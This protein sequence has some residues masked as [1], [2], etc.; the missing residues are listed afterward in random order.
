MTNEWT[1]ELDE[2]IATVHLTRIHETQPTTEH[3]G[4]RVLP[5]YTRWRTGRTMCTRRGT[6]R[7]AQTRQPVCRYQDV[8]IH[9]IDDGLKEFDVKRRT[10]SSRMILII[11]TKARH[12]GLYTC[13]VV[14]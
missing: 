11:R 2:V 4:Y 7:H 9:R 3:E 12:T 13:Y 6:R 14:S 5:R 1:L 10:V 8:Q